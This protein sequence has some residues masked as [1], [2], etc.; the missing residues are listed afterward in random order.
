MMKTLSAAL[1][2]AV[3]FATPALAGD[4]VSASGAQPVSIRVSAAGLDL[5]RK[6]DVM[7]LRG[8]VHEA[9]AE[10]CNPSDSYYAQLTP[11]HDCVAK[12]RGQTDSIVQKMAMRANGSRYVQN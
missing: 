8:R 9:I 12:F 1:A 7:R 11:D 10:A 3:V 5:S 4:A 2:A 6:S